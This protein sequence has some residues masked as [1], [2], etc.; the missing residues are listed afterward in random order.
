MNSSRDILPFN[1]AQ[2]FAGV[3]DYKLQKLIDA[4]ELV[5]RGDG[6]DAPQFFAALARQD[7]IC[8]RPAGASI[9]TGS[10]RL[11]LALVPGF[12][13][14]HSVE[15]SSERLPGV[16]YDSAIH[17]AI[18]AGAKVFDDSTIAAITKV[19]W[20]SYGDPARLRIGDLKLAASLIA[21]HWPSL[22]LWRD[23]PCWRDNSPPSSTTMEF[24][25]SLRAALEAALSLKRWT[26][27]LGRGQVFGAAASERILSTMRFWADRVPNFNPRADGVANGLQ[28]S[29]IDLFDRAMADLRRWAGQFYDVYVDHYGRGTC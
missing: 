12:A 29:T 11:L 20:L 6:L 28:G 7:E 10:P 1:Q 15:T 27:H 23:P 18:R 25:P 24:Y 16:D 5:R 19:I 8:N 14:V 21:G 3:S 26:I 13:E 9:A 2:D 4:G 22:Q 17:Q